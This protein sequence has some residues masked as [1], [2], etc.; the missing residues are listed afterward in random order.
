M[1]LV[2]RGLVGSMGI[3]QRNEVI[4]E[5]RIRRLAHGFRLDQTHVVVGCVYKTILVNDM[6]FSCEREVSFVEPE[7]KESY[8]TPCPNQPD[9]PLRFRENSTSR[10]DSDSVFTRTI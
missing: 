9:W 4:E 2:R 8:R 10:V 7:N 6:M 1:V 3:F 5:I